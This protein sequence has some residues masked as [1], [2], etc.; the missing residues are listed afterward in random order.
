MITVA[1]RTLIVYILI[2][3][4]LRIMGKRQLGELQP[5]ELVTTILVSNL[6]SLPVE[7]TELPLVSSLLP[8]LLIVSL[9]ILVSYFEVRSQRVSEVV[10]GKPKVVIVDGRIDQSVLRELRFS[11]DDLLEALRNKDVFDPREVAYGIVETNGTLN[12]YKKYESREVSNADLQLKNGG[13]DRPPVALVLD[14][15]VQ[16]EA[17]ALCAMTQNELARAIDG[18]NLRL[19]EIFLL[20]LDSDGKYF[21][22]KKEAEP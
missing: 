19:S 12:I 16:E 18:L 10:S 1:V 3:G 11:I 8:V 5:S 6:A 7:D 4:M 13:L 17:V 21:V 22:I 15:V 2:I 9:E 20:Q 14:G